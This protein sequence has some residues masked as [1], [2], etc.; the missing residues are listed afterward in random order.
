MSRLEELRKAVEDA[1][2]CAL[3]ADAAWDAYCAEAYADYGMML[4]AADAKWAA[5]EAY[6]KAMKELSDYKKEHKL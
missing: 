5:Y 4:N 6:S 3:A 2:R 1:I